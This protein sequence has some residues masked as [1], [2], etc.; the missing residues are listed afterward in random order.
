[1]ETLL[2]AGL[3]NAVAATVLA[4]V[5]ACLSRP[6]ARRPA[7]L[8]GLWLLVL[9]KLVTPPIYEVPIPWPISDSPA[10]ASLSQVQL[11]QIQPEVA[12][13]ERDGSLP[14]DSDAYASTDLSGAE[15]AV[16]VD[17]PI[18][19]G[20]VTRSPLMT[21]TYSSF[22][23]RRWAVMAWAAGSL[24]MLFVSCRRIGRFQRLIR[25]A[26]PATGEEREWLE[27]LA[28]EIGV[29]RVP[30]LFWVRARLSPL[31]WSL[32]WRPRLILPQ[33]LWKTLDERQRSTL[34]AHELAHLKRGDHLVRFLE[35][36]VTALYWWHPLLWWIRQ[37]LRDSEE[38][39]CDAWVVW[40]FPG[41]AKSYAE[42]LLDTLDFMHRS[43]K[44]EPLLA[45]GLGKVPHL[46]RR[47][48]MIMT[49]TTFRVLGVRGTLGLLVLGGAMLPVGATWAQQG[50][51]PRDVRVVV[52]ADDGAEQLN[53][54]PSHRRRIEQRI[55]RCGGESEAVAGWQGHRHLPQHP[56]Q[57][58]PQRCGPVRLH[59]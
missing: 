4:L 28:G 36:V 58:G 27:V 38:Q 10:E 32:G 44:A 2:R 30:D 26:A 33:D 43:A 7:V 49:G 20:L 25:S 21:A 51:E 9:L 1:M 8:H 13:G 5:V 53:S 17:D 39:C 23:W 34:V 15:L 45:S 41:A 56:G 37:S 48:T 47:L 12:S 6:L 40:M 35:L 14:D 54:A 22:D 46:R 16:I 31:V 18:G 55:R 42:T 59:R 52:K 24:V 11:I 50:P 3:S 19:A 57:D 29:R